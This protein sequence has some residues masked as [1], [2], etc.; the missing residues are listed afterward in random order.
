MS[1]RDYYQICAPSY[2]IY[3]EIKQAKT[4]IQLM[5]T[6]ISLIS[7]LIIVLKLITPVFVKIVLRLLQPKITKPERGNQ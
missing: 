3:S 4:F 7:G 6:L 1:F 2:C 5:V